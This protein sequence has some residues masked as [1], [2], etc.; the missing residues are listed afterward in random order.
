MFIW[1]CHCIGCFLTNDAVYIRHRHREAWPAPADGPGTEFGRQSGSGKPKEDSSAQADLV[2]SSSE[3]GLRRHHHRLGSVDNLPVHLQHSQFRPERQLSLG[4]Q[5][6]HHSREEFETPSAPPPPSVPYRPCNTSPERIRN[7]RERPRRREVRPSVRRTLLSAFRE[8]AQAEPNATTPQARALATSSGLASLFEWSGMS[9]SQPEPPRSPNRNDQPQKRE[10]TGSSLNDSSWITN[11]SG[12]ADLSD[13]VH[14]N[15]SCIDIHEDLAAPTRWGR[16]SGSTRPVKVPHIPLTTVL[17]MRT[18]PMS[19]QEVQQVCYGVSLALCRLHRQGVVHRHVCPDTILVDDPFDIKSV[20]LQESALCA[21]LGDAPCFYDTKLVGPAAF[22][23]PEVACCNRGSV[24]YSRACDMWALGATV[25]AMMRPQIP[26]PFGRRGIAACLRDGPGQYATV[27]EQQE[28]VEARLWE[29]MNGTSQA[30]SPHPTPPMPVEIQVFVQLLMGADP[31]QRAS[32]EYVLTKTWVA[33]FWQRSKFSPTVEL[34]PVP[35]PSMS[36]SSS[37]RNISP[38]SSGLARTASSLSCRS[39]RKA[40]LP[41]SDT[42]VGQSIADQATRVHNPVP[43]PSLKKQHAS[44]RNAS[45]FALIGK[46]VSDWWGSDGAKKNDDTS[47]P[48][49]E[50]NTFWCDVFCM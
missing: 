7:P 16:G 36:A 5:R 17:S 37:S 18:N 2:R 6:N 9:F 12:T 45:C 24:P 1:R 28:W 32:A 40:S 42:G 50:S 27:D 20:V 39:G 29:Y 21:P 30:W 22:C 49:K 31:A 3:G 11:T 10:S 47:M 4:Q 48:R 41:A 15:D 46:M 13:S 35:S 19:T 23:S 14:P 44:P 38:A 33:N 43:M 26:G 34:P 25:L 8:S